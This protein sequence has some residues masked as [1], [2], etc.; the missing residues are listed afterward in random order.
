MNKTS[1]TRRLL[2]A[3]LAGA[4]ALP[5]GYA[6]START[7]RIV[8]PYPP[9]G[10]QDAM[11]RVIQEP[12]GQLLGKIVVIEN[13]AGAAGMLGAQL[14]KQAPPDGTL[15]LFNNGMV[16]TPLVQRGAAIDFAK[17]MVPVS[18]IGEAPMLIF[19]NA[20]LPVTD[21]NGLVTFAKAKPGELAFASTGVGGL[22][23]LTMETFTRRAGINLV[24]I[25][26][27]GNAPL[28]L[29][30]ISGETPLGIGTVSD[31]MLQN[32]RSGKLRI[33]GATTSKASAAAPGVAPI[34]ET[35]PGFDVAATFAFLA[36]SGTSARM[37][38]ELHDAVVKVLEESDVKER[39]LSY[40]VVPRSST[41]EKVTE[42]VAE[43]SARWKAAVQSAGIEAK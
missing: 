15:L 39:Y 11:M 10:T 6:Q 28:M 25:P 37:V 22:G 8:V 33:L 13:R 20:S 34:A 31:T 36:P 12:L 7:L 26:Y 42:L 23:H 32:V 41:P 19:C 21:I 5:A 9:G 43:E 35:L 4:F 40:G 3:G 24:H 17:E 38:Q 29:A 30:V 18:L 16:I 1:S 27:K 14:V 2:L